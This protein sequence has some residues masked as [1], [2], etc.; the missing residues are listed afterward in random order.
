[1]KPAT[2]ADDASVLVESEAGV[3]AARQ[4]GRELAADL[5]FSATEQTL[6]ATAIS[7]IARNIIQYAGKGEIWMTRTQEDGRLGIKV[8]AKDQGPGIA[9]LEQAMR[10]GFSTGRGMGLGLPGARRL[11]DQFHSESEPGHGTT[12]VMR[13]WVPTR[14]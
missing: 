7:E 13:K 11:M 10:D 6:I 4:T 9:D 14:G 5:G 2:V 1:M 8:T 12:I 3:V